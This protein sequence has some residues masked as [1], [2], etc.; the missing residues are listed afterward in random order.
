MKAERRPETC[1]QC[2][3]LRRDK[4]DRNDPTVRFYC[5]HLERMRQAGRIVG[6]PLAYVLRSTPGCVD[7]TRRSATDQA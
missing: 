6:R 2:A 5:G 4:L 3:D 7:G 1:G